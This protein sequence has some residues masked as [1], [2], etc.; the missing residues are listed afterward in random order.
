MVDA[1]TKFNPFKE[2]GSTGLRQWSGIISEPTLPQLTGR[3]AI[4]LY[5][6][7]ANF[8]P[9]IAA[10][11]FATKMPTRGVTWTV[12]S[13]GT[14]ADADDAADFVEDV[15]LRKL[16]WTEVVSEALS[17]IE[18]G[19]APMELVWGRRQDGKI[20]V[21]KLSLRSQDTIWRWD[22]EQGSNEL[23]G[24]YQRIPTTGQEV[25]I[26]KDRFLL[27]RTV[28]FKDNPEG[29]SALRGAVIPYLRK[30]EIEA[31]EGAAAMRAAGIVVLRIPSVAMNDPT[32]KGNW[33]SLVTSV[34]NNRAGYM[35]LP[36]DKD[37][38]GNPYYEISYMVADGR[39]PADMGTIIS[40]YDQRIATTLLAD[41]ILLGHDMQGSF[42]LSSDKTALF[43]QAVG[44]WL[45]AIAEVVNRDLIPRLWK[46]N[47]MDEE[48]MPR[49]VPGDLE[50]PNLGEIGDFVTKLAGAG[51]RMFPDD[52]LE[53]RLRG[54]ASLPPV[55]EDGPAA[56]LPDAA[57]SED[58][59]VEET[60]DDMVAKA[61][62][63]KALARLEPK[64]GFS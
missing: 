53:N 7:M 41:F 61:K 19:F 2:I 26:P 33:E 55:P 34:A 4:N 46:L 3:Q 1:T 17:M 42:A 60:P 14:G 30:K 15:L 21:K 8:D 13:A 28:S 50:T 45:G 40:R 35:I 10:I 9:V 22:M 43:A 58:E 57:E 20:G 18:Y 5:R 24:L 51:A 49:L 29:Y 59:L 38:K 62:F 6:E 31:I 44:A 36:S 25:Y 39:R 27:F 37:D 54:F 56:D 47:G 16:R 32:V 48:I 63:A 52:E 64:G 11:L 12:E 23:K